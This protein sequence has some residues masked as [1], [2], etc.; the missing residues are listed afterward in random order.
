MTG[1]ELQSNKKPPNYL[2]LGTQ[3]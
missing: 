1:E 3:S 2:I